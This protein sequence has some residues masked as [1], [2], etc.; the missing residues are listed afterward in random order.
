MRSQAGFSLIELMVSAALMLI[1]MVAVTR[2][3]TTQQ[4][5]YI[6]VDQVTEAQQNLR[7]IADLVERDVRRAGYMVPANAAVCAYDDTDGPDTLFV[8]K[9]DAIRT[10]YDLEDENLSLSANKGAKVAGAGSTF[11]ATGASFS[12]TVEQLWADYDDPGDP[13]DNVD[14]AVGE[15]VIVASEYNEDASVA[16]GK[17]TAIS[18]KTLT[19]N[20]GGTSTGAV[21]TNAGVLAIPAHVY[22]LSLG[23]SGNPNRLLRNG[24]LLASDVEDFQVTWFFDDDGDLVVDASEMHGT[25]LGVDQPWELSP[26]A[27]RPNFSTLREVGVNL[28]TVTRTD[29]PNTDYQMGAGQVTG[30]RD[31]SSLP[32]GDGKRRRVSSTRVRLRNVLGEDV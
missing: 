11:N 8:S 24:Q 27:N 32:S 7:A 30:N 19:V 25:A 31:A 22:E 13:D 17:I 10:V 1:L 26:L 18:G 16:C 28:V 9:T 20:F 15:G 2:A 4:H 21:G 5:T 6:V 3:F 12:L 23:T 14:F 29:D